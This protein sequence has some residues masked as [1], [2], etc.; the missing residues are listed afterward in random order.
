MFDIKNKMAKVSQKFKL[1][2][3]RFTSAHE[4]GHAILHNQETLFRD[5]ALNGGATGLVRPQI[6]IEADAFAVFFLMP[7]V[8]V[9]D[10]FA[11]IFGQEQFVVDKHSAFALGFA[12]LSEMQSKLPTPRHLATRLATTDLCSG[13]P[14]RSLCEIF[15]VS[16]SAMAIRIEELS[17]VSPT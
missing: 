11:Q 1:D 10:I 12:N 16:P 15:G 8:Q 13:I 17:L 9:R 2:V 7:E 14:T 6:E 4:L 3:R 5:R